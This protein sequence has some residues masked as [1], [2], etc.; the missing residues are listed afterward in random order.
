MIGVLPTSRA[1]E[2]L[3]QAATS[4]FMSPVK[5]SR[6]ADLESESRP[7]ENIF[8]KNKHLN[9]QWRDENLNETPSMA[10]KILSYV[11]DW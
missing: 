9:M 10:A 1:L 2:Q 4:S 11:F 5:R 3:N 7:S 6:M 8:A